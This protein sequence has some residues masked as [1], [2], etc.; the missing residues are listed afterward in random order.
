MTY[1]PKAPA[2]EEPPASG[3]V[4]FGV[5]LLAFLA[6]MVFLLLSGKSV[7]QDVRLIH[8]LKNLDAYYE[9]VPAKW[10]KVEVRRDTSGKSDYYPDVLFDAN[11]HGASVWGW[12]LSLEEA[13][14]DSQTWAKRLANY[15]VGDTVT[16]WVD[17]H[18][19]KDSFIEKRNDG[20]QRV[21]SKA[22]L[23][24]AFGLFGATLV[25]LSLFGWIRAGFGKATQKNR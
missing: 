6:G 15:R 14:D 9:P 10:I 20:L 3:S 21:L 7:T 11:V 22:L 5:Q 2:P 23:G 1:R 17:R 12:R 19:P 18:D 16:A 4:P 13:P 24:G 8:R 25:V